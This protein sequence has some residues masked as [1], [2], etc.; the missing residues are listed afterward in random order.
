MDI[1][2]I[3]IPRSTPSDAFSHIYWSDFID[4]SLAPVHRENKPIGEGAHISTEPNLEAKADFDQLSSHRNEE[5]DDTMASVQDNL[6]Q[7]DP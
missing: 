3:G 2:P 4:S 5:L 1:K 7:N 6:T